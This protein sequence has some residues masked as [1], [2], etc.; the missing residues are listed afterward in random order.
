MT[1]EQSDVLQMGRNLAYLSIA[2]FPD[3]FTFF[4]HGSLAGE[5]IP[6]CHQCRN[7]CAGD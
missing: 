7:H 6:G 1:I 3:S 2:I 4:I 5:A